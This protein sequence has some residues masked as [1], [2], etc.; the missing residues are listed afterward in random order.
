MK[1]VIRITSFIIISFAFICKLSAQEGFTVRAKVPNPNNYKI[2]ITY[3]DGEKYTMDTS[4]IL[5][6]GY[7]VFKGSINGV[8]MANFVV[9]NPN[10]TIKNGNGVIPGPRLSFVVRNGATVII[11]GSTE[12]IYMATVQ[13]T[14]KETKAYETFRSKDKV[15]EDENWTM[16][17][18]MYAASAALGDKPNLEKDATKRNSVDKK[19]KEWA[20]KFVKK[21]PDTYAAIE[22]FSTYTLGLSDD[23]QAKQF[24]TLPGTYK[25][26]E[27]GKRIQEKID[28]T[29]ATAVGKP[30][31]PFSQKGYN[32]S[33]VDLAAI[34]GKV[35]LIDFWGS[36][37]VPCRK[38]F[39]HLKE[40]YAKYKDKG[41]EIVGVAQENGNKENQDKAWRGAIQADGINWLNVLNDLSQMNIVKNYGVVV[42]P[43]IILVDRN[44][45]IQGRFIGD[46]ADHF[47]KKLNE[48]LQSPGKA[49]PKSSAK[50]S[51]N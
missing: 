22:V 30:I 49:E 23:E 31:I 7:M 4:Y 40:L 14:D 20:M 2:L 34:K 33:L 48:L 51:G 32:E 10:N 27:L 28:G 46:Q 50:T 25:N 19:R 47:E 38:S 42:F 24:A 44:G 18:E 26:S 9:R 36:W 13:G 45:V 1:K 16:K 3:S 5:E 12:K 29:A 41:F 35:V 11:E 15:W 21:Y 17:K 43:T 8:G 39:P 6:K 37:C